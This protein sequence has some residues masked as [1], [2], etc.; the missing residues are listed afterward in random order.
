M[1]LTAWINTNRPHGDDCDEAG[2]TCL[3]ITEVGTLSE[4]D[5]NAFDYVVMPHPVQDRGNM[6]SEDA[7]RDWIV[8][9][10]DMG[11]RSLVATRVTQIEGPP[12]L[13]ESSAADV[14]LAYHGDPGCTHWWT[15]SSGCR[16]R[17]YPREIPFAPHPIGDSPGWL[18]LDSLQQ[19]KVAY[20]G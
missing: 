17:L 2:G 5:E 3:A 11:F 13:D 4:M 10:I 20:D 6:S 9:T 14:A 7:A 16:W 18:D 15:A 8:I 1:D 19:V 12:K